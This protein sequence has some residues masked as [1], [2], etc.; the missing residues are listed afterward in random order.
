MGRTQT[1]LGIGLTLA[2][3][4]V[5]LHG[6][7]VT[8][9]SAGLGMG[10]CFTVHLPL[11]PT[12]TTGDTANKSIKTT[13]TAVLRILVV[14]DNQE[15][16]TTLGKLI[17]LLGHEVRTEY[18]GLSALKTAE[19]FVPDMVLLDIG[20]PDINGFEV[21]KRMRLLPSLQKTIFVAQTGW[22][23]KRHYALS[24][25]AGFDHHLVKPIEFD[26]LRNLLD[27]LG[28]QPTHDRS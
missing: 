26:W 20:M 18:N 13:S 9:D 11:L 6:G 10:S 3:Q 7:K 15:S 17:E 4:L 8:A 5:Q 25:D 22:G 14:D 1:G 27:L 19:T 2:E 24:R 23:E 21:C 28:N 12:E 16:A